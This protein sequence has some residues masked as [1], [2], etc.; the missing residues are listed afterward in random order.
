MKNVLLISVLALTMLFSVNVF[1]VSITA[2]SP[3]YPK[4]QVVNGHVDGWYIDLYA[5]CNDS[6]IGSTTATA[7][8]GTQA[9]GNSVTDYPGGNPA[10]YSDGNSF[11]EDDGYCYTMT[12][13]VALNGNGDD[14]ASAT[15]GVW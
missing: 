14:Y 4:S 5:N 6:T 7:N 12:A 2:T 13:S 9:G 15:V 8:T 1:A 11:P 3:F 10:T